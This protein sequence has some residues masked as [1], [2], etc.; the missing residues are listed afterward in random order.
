MPSRQAYSLFLDLNEFTLPLFPEAI[1]KEK[2]AFNDAVTR[3]LRAAFAHLNGILKST[4]VSDARLEIVWQEDPAGTSTSK[5]I[6]EILTGGNYADGILLLELFLSGEPEEPVL[7]FNLGMAYSDRDNLDRAI[8]L[9]KKLVAIQPGHVNGRVA[10]GVALLRNGQDAEGLR[11]LETALQQEPRNLW[12]HRNLAAGLVRLGRHSE[13]EEHFRLATEIDPNDQG[14]W[15]GYGQALEE[16]GKPQEADHAYHKIIALDEYSALAELAKKALSKLA[17]KNFQSK[18]PGTPRM[19]AVMYC[20]TAL[21][22][23]AKLS[24]DQVKAIGFEIALLGTRGLDVNSSEAK[25]TLKN[26]AGTF[27]GVQLVCYEYVSFQ[28]F[29]PAQDIGFDLSAEYQAA[30]KLFEAKGQ[31]K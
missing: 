14:S 29:A 5:K 6:A 26:M 3:R 21:E 20:L 25:Y 4:I 16:S 24:P 10:L 28:Q 15:L 12:A 7:L 23:F 18:T 1:G 2:S 27:S 17:Q 31:S 8:A 19:D 22:K 11:E 13:A 30:W 9:L